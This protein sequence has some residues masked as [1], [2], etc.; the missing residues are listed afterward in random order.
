MAPHSQINTIDGAHKVEHR[1]GA[2]VKSSD[3]NATLTSQTLM[4]HL[5]RN[6][7]T[8]ETEELTQTIYGG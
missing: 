1:S 4:M 7:A 5:A 2:T 6:Q 3:G 8:F